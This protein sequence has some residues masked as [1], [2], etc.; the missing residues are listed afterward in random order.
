MPGINTG[1]KKMSNLIKIATW[2]QLLKTAVK[3]KLNYTECKNK[4]QI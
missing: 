4:T 2:Q 3:N 1:R